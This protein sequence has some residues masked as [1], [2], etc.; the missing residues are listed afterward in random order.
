MPKN[1]GAGGKNRR[2]GK[3]GLAGPKELVYKQEGEEYAQVVRSIGN[4]YMEIKTFTANGPTLKRAHIRGAM[5][6]KAWMA[7]GDIVLISTR[8]YSDKTCDILHKYNTTEAKLLQARK[9]LPESIEL[10]QNEQIAEEDKIN[11]ADNPEDEDSEEDNGKNTV[12]DQNRNFG[13]P[14]S[15][16][17]SE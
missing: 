10:N 11:F 4:G 14:P 15:D 8:G 1:K 7:P 6:K 12:P 17:E 2:R 16:S 5:R 9:Q 13:L 3:T